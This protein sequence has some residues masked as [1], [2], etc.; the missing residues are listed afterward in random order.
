[1]RASGGS[2]VRTGG[3]LSEVRGGHTRRRKECGF[4]KA[5]LCKTGQK[6]SEIQGRRTLRE[7]RGRAQR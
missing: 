5:L 2:C 7:G 6:Y 1:M 3:I 4:C